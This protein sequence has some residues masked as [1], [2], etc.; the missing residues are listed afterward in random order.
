MWNNVQGARSYFYWLH[1]L[2]D[3]SLLTTGLSYNNSVKLVTLAAG[4]RYQFTVS[5]F[6]TAGNGTQ[7]VEDFNTGN[8][9]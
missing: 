3:S 1:Y 2:N 9:T 8:R 6:N 4:R 7:T 5:A